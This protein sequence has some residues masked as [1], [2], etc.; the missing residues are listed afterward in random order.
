VL[1]ELVD[2]LLADPAA[3]AWPWRL[4][5]GAVVVV[6]LLGCSALTYRLVEAPAQRAGRWL[7][8]R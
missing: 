6:V 1:L 5:L 4:W 8:R 3:V 7:L 2:G